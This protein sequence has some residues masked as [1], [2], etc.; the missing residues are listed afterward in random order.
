MRHLLG[1]SEDRPS[2]ILGQLE[3]MALSVEHP[4]VQANQ[5]RIRKQEVEVLQCLAEP[6]ALHLVPLVVL[7]VCSSI[8]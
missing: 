4:I 8:E 6:K 5:S 3:R 7:Q 1:C 2:V